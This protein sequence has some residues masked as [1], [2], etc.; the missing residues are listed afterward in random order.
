MVLGGM[1]FVKVYLVPYVPSDGGVS[2]YVTEENGLRHT[3]VVCPE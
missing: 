2:G 1:M 3:T